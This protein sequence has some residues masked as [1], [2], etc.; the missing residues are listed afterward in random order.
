MAN[1][2]ICGHSSLHWGHV[3]MVKRLWHSEYL[4]PNMCCTD[5]LFQSDWLLKNVPPFGDKL[6]YLCQRLGEARNTSAYCFRCGA[7]GTW[8]SHCGGVS[9]RHSKT[10]VYVSMN[11]RTMQKK[12]KVLLLFIV[13][14]LMPQSQMPHLCQKCSS[15]AQ[16]LQQTWS[17]GNTDFNRFLLCLYYCC[18][19]V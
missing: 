19:Y 14:S 3:G 4:I 1:R 2:P 18:F 11:I 7:I 8:P 9:Q 12:Y 13:W 16:E 5:H 6:E 10:F 17:A 15:S